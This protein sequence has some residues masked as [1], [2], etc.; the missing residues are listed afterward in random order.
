VVKFDRSTFWIRHRSLPPPRAVGTCNFVDRNQ[1][2]L[3]KRHLSLRQ[4]RY[5]SCPHFFQHMCLWDH[6]PALGLMLQTHSPVPQSLQATYTVSTHILRYKKMRERQVGSF[7]GVKL[8][9]WFGRLL[10]V[11][12]HPLSYTYRNP[13]RKRHV[14]SKESRVEVNN[15]LS[16]T[17]GNIDLEIVLRV[18]FYSQKYFSLSRFKVNGITCRVHVLQ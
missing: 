9:V 18:A 6:S 17:E 3:V 15:R 2:L 11:F 1:P 7:T 10:P 8:L 14:P 16:I 4:Q 13:T 12:N 5:V